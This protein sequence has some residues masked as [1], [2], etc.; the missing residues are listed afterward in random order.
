MF[1]PQATFPADIVLGARGSTHPTDHTEF[2]KQTRNELRLAFEFARCN[3][4]ERADKRV[5]ANKRLP[6]YPVFK[7]GEQVVLVYRPH[8]ISDGPNPKL[9]I[10]WRGP[11]IIC[12]QSS[13]VA[14][15]VKKQGD[16][17]EVSTHIAHL[18]K[19]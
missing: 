2:S 5:Q 11:Y 7:A 17:K 1:G 19:Y 3:L 15:R 16:T 8:Q 13:P 12:S 18:K 4:T 6:P 9:G 14:Y 10:P